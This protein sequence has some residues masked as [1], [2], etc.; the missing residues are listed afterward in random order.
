MHDISR[1]KLKHYW[2]VYLLVLPPL[3]LVLVFSYYPIY[4][5]FVHIFY[6][7]NGDNIEEFIGFGNIVRMF[8]DVDLWRS[9][10]VVGIFIVA[11]LIKMIPPIITAVVLH[12]IMSGRAQYIYRV[13]FV[14]PMIVPMMM[15]VIGKMTT[16][17][18][19]NVVLI[20]D[21]IL[22]IENPPNF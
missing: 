2:P 9:F 22:S 17:P 19:M 4:N 20:K 7:W 5:G 3:L 13:F 11:N 18:P 6:R 21:L 8:K 1:E 10:S 15:I 16:T 12:H 14:I